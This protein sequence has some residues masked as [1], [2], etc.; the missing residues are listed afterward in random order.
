[1]DQPLHKLLSDLMRARSSVSIYSAIGFV[2][3]STR[4]FGSLR[5]VLADVFDIENERGIIEGKIFDIKITVIATLLFVTST[6]VT[7][8]VTLATS[9][10]LSALVALR[11]RNDVM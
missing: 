4:L 9:R 11:I 6:A 2:W 3:F 1:P 7:T 10:G 5:T 8:Y